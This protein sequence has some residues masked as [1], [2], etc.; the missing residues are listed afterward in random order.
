[1]R[2]I[3][4]NT[5]EFLNRVQGI[6]TETWKLVKRKNEQYATNDALANFSTGADLQYHDKAAEWQFE[7][8]K[9]YM[10]KHVAHVY[11]NRLMGN[12]VRESLGD[13][14]TYCIIG[15]IMHDAIDTRPPEM[16]KKVDYVDIREVK[17]RLE[18]KILGAILISER[19]TTIAMKTL[20]IEDISKPVHQTIFRAMV[21]I[22]PNQLDLVSVTE[23][24]KMKNALALIGG[25]SYITL[26]G[27]CVPNDADIYHDIADLMDINE[28]VIGDCVKVE[29]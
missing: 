12:G 8:L 19:A 6:L 25:V 2:K 29:C 11:N 1:M 20:S 15:M 14:A 17:H 27:N 9:D 13:I 21:S 26:L 7:T 23:E 5:A 28:K 16:T 3:N 4:M 18:Q 10:L 22:Y 24:L